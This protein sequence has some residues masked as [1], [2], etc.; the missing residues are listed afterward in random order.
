MNKQLKTLVLFVSKRVCPMRI[1]MYV[2]K[3]PSFLSFI[4]CLKCFDFCILSILSISI[5][6]NSN[7]NLVDSLVVIRFIGAN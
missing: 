4:A 7:Q 5:Q 2:L 1:P 3:K 6:F